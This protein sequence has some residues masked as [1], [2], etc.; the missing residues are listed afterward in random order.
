MTT[1]L[2]LADYI[3]SPKPLV[4]SVAKILRAESRIMDVLPFKDIG[5]MSAEAWR[6]GSMPAVSWRNIGA[7]HGSVLATKPDKVTEQV[8][9]IGNEIIVDKM[10]ARDNSTRLVDP[11]TYQTQMITKAIARNFSNIVINGLETDLSN[12]V[13]LWHRTLYDLPS[14]QRINANVDISP[15]KSGLAAEIQTF[16]DKLDELLY[17]V[18]DTLDLGGN[19]VYLL[20]NDTTLF[21]VNSI[22]R[23][24]GLVSHTQDI[25][26][27]MWMEYKGAKF[28]DMGLK[29]D[30]STKIIGNVESGTALTGG[31][32]TSIYAI[33][34]GPEHFTGIQEYGLEVSDFEL[35]DD[36]VTYKSVI[37]WA[38]GLALVHPRSAARLYG[39]TA[40]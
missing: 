22:F 6:E 39:I 14:T 1:A 29:Y 25:L 24:S 23:Q 7:D 27:R 38:V 34:V 3:A 18:N 9:S 32:A 37:D 20:C 12:P 4:S 21:R 17:A 35:M 19:G 15:D 28:I 16:I 33:K 11:M 40:L 26:G 10:Y 8:Y 5:A 30:E 36:K 2:T 31:A 13:G